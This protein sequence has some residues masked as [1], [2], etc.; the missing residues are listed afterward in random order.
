MEK[1]T[2]II[3]EQDFFLYITVWVTNRLSYVVTRG[4][5]CN[6]FLNA[7]A[8]HELSDGPQDNFY[9]ELEHVDHFPRYHQNY[10]CIV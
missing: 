9:E 1:E 4:R 6:N 5:W 2:K 10:I 7:H 3:W 8:P